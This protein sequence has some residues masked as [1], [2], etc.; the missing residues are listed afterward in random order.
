MTQYDERDIPSIL[1]LHFIDELNESLMVRNGKNV[2]KASVNMRRAF[3]LELVCRTDE[4]QV[5]AEYAE[6][7]KLVYTQKLET[8]VA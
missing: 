1:L 7:N 5:A 4:L 6:K 3:T 2:N 8:R